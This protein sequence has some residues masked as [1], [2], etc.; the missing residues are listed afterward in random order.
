M[1]TSAASSHA[2]TAPGP[3][4]SRMRSITATGADADRAAHPERRRLV[5]GEQAAGRKGPARAGVRADRAADRARDL[6]RADR[7]VSRRADR[8]LLDRGRDRR[9]R[10][11]DD[12]LVVI[13]IAFT[14][15]SER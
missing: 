14:V 1:V 7:A 11:L 8:R 5:A 9:A 3:Q 10:M 12:A 6:G 4:R 2:R 13:A 15:Q